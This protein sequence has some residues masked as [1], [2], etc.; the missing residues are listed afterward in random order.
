MALEVVDGKL[1]MSWNFGFDDGPMF[2]TVTNIAD[3]TQ[4]SSFSI[5]K[6]G[7][8]T[9]INI[10]VLSFNFKLVPIHYFSNM[11]FSFVSSVCVYLF[12]LSVD[13][14][15]FNFSVCEYSHAFIFHRLPTPSSEGENIKC[16]EI[17]INIWH[18]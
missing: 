11:Y 4:S 7:V 12:V 18:L 15:A 14:F 8:A 13:S 1:V 5:I 10:V 2:R 9:S 6:A 3:I 16:S 17:K